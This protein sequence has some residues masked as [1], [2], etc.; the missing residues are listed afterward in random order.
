MKSEKKIKKWGREDEKVG[1]P[2]RK[3][4]GLKIM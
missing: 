1:N 3:I 2:V 4:S